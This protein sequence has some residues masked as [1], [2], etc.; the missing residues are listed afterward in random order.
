MDRKTLQAALGLKGQGNFR[1]RYLA[2]SLATGLIEMS[3]PDKPNSRN[4]KYRLTR[5]GQA[6]RATLIHREKP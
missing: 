2:P 6:L 3:L 4:Q 1:E 5:R